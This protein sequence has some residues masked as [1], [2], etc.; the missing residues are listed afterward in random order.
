MLK[1]LIKRGLNRLG[2][3]LIKLEDYYTVEEDR[4]N[5]A[6]WQ[7]VR[8]LTTIGLRGILAN[9]DAVDYCCANVLPGALV[10]CGVWRGGSVIAM[11]RKLQ[12]RGELDREVYLFDTFAG[13][14]EPGAEDRRGGRPAGPRWRQGCRGEGNAWCY[15]SLSEVRANI[16]RTGYPMERIHF[17]AGDVAETLPSAEVSA[18]ALLRLDTDWYDS[19]RL[20][21]EQLYDRVVPGG[22]VIVDDYG[23]WEGARQAVKEFL[24]DRALNPLMSR[25]DHSGRL[26]VKP[27]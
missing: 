18:I 11:L 22:V 24:G 8:E 26:F 20:E 10:E 2:Y 14:T 5:L 19:T 4:A 16:A 7:E 15:A 21:L 17:V 1:R 12:Q 6:V 25:I 9:L 13:M 3:D 23:A 27:G